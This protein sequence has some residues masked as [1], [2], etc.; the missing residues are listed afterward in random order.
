MRELK[1]FEPLLARA[2]RETGDRVIDS[3]HG[4]GV[5]GITSKELGEKV[6][7]VG[8]WPFR[9]WM[10]GAVGVDPDGVVPEGG[11]SVDCWP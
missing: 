10:M 1:V 4:F 2:F 9:D 11:L 5:P 8:D 7:V 6:D 3:S